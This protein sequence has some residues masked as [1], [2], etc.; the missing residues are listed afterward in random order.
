MEALKVSSKHMTETSRTRRGPRV[1]PC[2]RAR[3]LP[4]ILLLGWGASG[5]EDASSSGHT[6]EIV[7]AW[8]QSGL[9]PSVFSS[10]D[11]ETLKPGK[12]QQ[13][14]V[15]GVTVVL[16]EYADATAA[17]AAHKVGLDRVGENTGLSLAGSKYLLVVSD[18]DKADPS[19]RKINAI[20]EAFR[21]VVA[22]RKPAGGAATSATNDGKAP[23]GEGKKP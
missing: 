17:H 16:C 12:C 22:P 6:D 4:G 10:L 21:E 8:K 15:D 13:G 3:L 7:N 14:K 11:D 1:L 5:C 20:A 19:G 2:L 9:M 18:T 23:T